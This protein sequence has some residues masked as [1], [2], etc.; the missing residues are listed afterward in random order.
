[1]QHMS[2]QEGENR[3][4]AIPRGGKERHGQG[5]SACKAGQA[6]RMKQQQLGVTRLAGCS[7]RPRAWLAMPSIGS[8]KAVLKFEWPL[9]C[10]TGS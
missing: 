7:L 6:A 5:T 1:M 3:K 10:A 8:V 9:D 4:L 2:G